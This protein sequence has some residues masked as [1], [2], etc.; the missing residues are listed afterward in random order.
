MHLVVRLRDGS[1]A[2]G[3]ALVDLA[4]ARGLALY[5]MAPYYLDSPDRAELRMGYAALTVAEIEGA[6]AIFERCLDDM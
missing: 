1:R 4:R 2:D 3:D 6:L 5:P